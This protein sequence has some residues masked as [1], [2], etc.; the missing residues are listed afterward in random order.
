METQEPK[1]KIHFMDYLLDGI[2]FL[3]LLLVTILLYVNESSCI[4]TKKTLIEAKGAMVKV[5]DVSVVDEALNGKL[6]HATAFADTKEVLTDGLYDVSETA[7][8][9]RRRV[10]YYQYEEKSR[11][12]DKKTTY[13]YNK[14]WNSSPISS[15]NFHSSSHRNFVIVKIEQ[16]S[17]CANDARFG[18]YRLPK[19]IISSIGGGD[20]APVKVSNDELRQWEKVIADN[21]TALGKTAPDGVSMV[22]VSGN[23][24]YYGRS[25]SDPAIGD[26]RVTFT[27]IPPLQLSLIAKV[28]GDTFEKYMSDTGNTFTV[29]KRGTVSA[30]TMFSSAHSTNTLDAWVYRLILLLLSIIAWRAMF[31]ILP[32][33]IKSSVFL[34]SLR[35][36]GIKV[37][38][39]VVGCVWTCFVIAGTW[40]QFRP[41]VSI[42]LLSC[43]IAGITYLK[44]KGKTVQSD[45]S[46]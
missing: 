40:L 2:F 20:S 7:L 33:F 42:A 3:F 9:L 45:G 19:F 26:V 10:E 29:V 15:K 32:D 38:Q 11:R 37:F 24:V 13:Y 1:K 35:N 31:N 12:K 39:I 5:D 6:I 23:V 28:S 30:E 21:L 27:K 34:D 4:K 25:P 46:Q 41:L 43:V 18:G 16:Q 44:N 8:Y 36:A 14:E 17:V 22:H